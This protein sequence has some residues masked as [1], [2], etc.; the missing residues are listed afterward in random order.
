M[1]KGTAQLP[2]GLSHSDSSTLKAAIVVED[3][4]ILGWR[5]EAKDAMKVALEVGLEVGCASLVSISAANWTSPQGPSQCCWP[6]GAVR[7]LGPAVSRH[8][9]DSPERP[10]PSSR[11]VKHQWLATG[12]PHSAGGHLG[13]VLPPCRFFGSLA[14]AGF[15]RAL[16]GPS[17]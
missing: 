15:F 7:S 17:K 4:M 14:L 10:A 6:S 5:T 2:E 11:Y 9:F 8:R 13:V 3:W 1:L 16:H 12:P